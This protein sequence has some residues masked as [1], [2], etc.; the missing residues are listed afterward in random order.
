MDAE[1][2]IKSWAQE[3]L[4]K[5][6]DKITTRNI[7]SQERVDSAI[8]SEMDTYLSKSDNIDEEDDEQDTDDDEIDMDAIR[9][10]VRAQLQS[11]IVL[12][13]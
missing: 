3:I 13:L 4:K 12:M 8:F 2:K 11:I 6:K 1:E 7:S 5:E 9:A 10:K